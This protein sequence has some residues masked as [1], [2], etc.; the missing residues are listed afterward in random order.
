MGS[1]SLIS[2]FGLSTYHVLFQIIV[3]LYRNGSSFGQCSIIKSSA[4]LYKVDEAA[5]VDLK[6]IESEQQGKAEKRAERVKERL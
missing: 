3:C 6:K 1:S 5:V 2:M 4:T